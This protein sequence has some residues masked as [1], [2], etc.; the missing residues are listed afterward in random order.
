MENL[1]EGLTGF[2][3]A[4]WGGQGV[5]EDALVPEASK[6]MHHLSGPVQNHALDLVLSVVRAPIPRLEDG[7]DK[8]DRF[9]GRRLTLCHFNLKELDLVKP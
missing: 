8:R 5:A 2:P 9:T 1:F 4:L 7:G 3:D 6:T